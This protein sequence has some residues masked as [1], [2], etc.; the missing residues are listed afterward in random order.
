MPDR[1]WGRGKCACSLTEI[2]CHSMAAPSAAVVVWERRYIHQA[3]GPGTP[4]KNDPRQTLS[5]PAVATP[6]RCPDCESASALDV[7]RRR[8]VTPAPK[9]SAAALRYAAPVS[10]A[11]ATASTTGV[12]IARRLTVLCPRALERRKPSV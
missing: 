3:Q 6:R 11:R 9:P 5:H 12:S 4:G 8:N 7:H 2:W 1:S 10:D